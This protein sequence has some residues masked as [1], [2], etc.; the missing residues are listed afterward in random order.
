MPYRD[1]KFR[2]STVEIE[3]ERDGSAWILRWDL[4]DE[5]RHAS[6]AEALDVVRCRDRIMA[7]A[8]YSVITT[9]RWTAYSRIGRAVVRALQQ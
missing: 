5:E 8:G 4:G 3:E 1:R 7:N 6:A 9:I 2:A